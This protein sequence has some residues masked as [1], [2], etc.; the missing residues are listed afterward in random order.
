MGMHSAMMV[1][2]NQARIRA[3]IL[4]AERAPGTADKWLLEVEICQAMP[5]RGPQRAEP[6][7]R[8][9]AFTWRPD[10]DLPLPVQVE[11]DAEY[12]GGPRHG[13]FQLLN[14]HVCP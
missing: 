8:A 14:L 13:S 4:R 1:A 11:A 2:P 6:G 7:L 12:I 3:T 5:V 9:P 10:W